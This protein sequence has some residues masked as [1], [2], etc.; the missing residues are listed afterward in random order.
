MIH[1]FRKLSCLHLLHLRRWEN[2]LTKMA[3]LFT[4]LSFK[5]LALEKTICTSKVGHIHKTG[6]MGAS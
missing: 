3:P 6:S 5:V 1:A 2:M 4:H